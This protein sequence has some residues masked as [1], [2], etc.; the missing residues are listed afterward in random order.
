MF[1]PGLLH[2]SYGVKRRQVWL[3]GVTKVS[4]IQ[5]KVLVAFWKRCADATLPVCDLR[6]ILPRSPVFGRPWV[7]AAATVVSRARR[8]G[9]SGDGMMRVSNRICQYPCPWRGANAPTHNQ[10][11]P[12]IQ[13]LGLKKRTLL[14]CVRGGLA[15]SGVRP[16]SPPPWRVARGDHPT[17]PRYTRNRACG[18]LFS[19]QSTSW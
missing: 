7:C 14:P 4:R 16:P 3:L 1:K 8:I 18:H 5:V 6:Q 10:P 13:P 2:R 9:M 17:P 12:P 11:E 19:W 15:P